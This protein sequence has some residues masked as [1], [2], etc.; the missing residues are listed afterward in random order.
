MVYFRSQAQVSIYQGGEGKGSI[1]ILRHT[2]TLGAWPENRVMD[3]CIQ[4]LSSLVLP[5]QSRI[6]CLGDCVHC[7]RLFP[8]P[9][10]QL[11]QPPTDMPQGQPN[12]VSPSLKL[13]PA[14]SRLGTINTDQEENIGGNLGGPE[15]NKGL[16]HMTLYE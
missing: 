8:P 12:L 7:G 11:R 4:V 2:A 14:D 16:L 3:A 10:V 6:P 1:K 15:L 13:F 9:L 5:R